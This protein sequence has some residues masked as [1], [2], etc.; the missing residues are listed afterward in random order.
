MRT[1]IDPSGR[2][3][4]PKRIRDRLGL[5]GNE[6]VEITERDGRIEIEPAPTDVEL[7]RDGSVLV[8]RP[9]RPLPPLT[10]DIVRETLE[11]VRRCGAGHQ[12]PGGGIRDWHEGTEH[13]LAG[14]ATYD[15]VVGLTARRRGN[16]VDP[17][18]ARS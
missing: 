13:D 3:V 14:G 7:V 5:R 9:G 4:I 17:R 6:E 15:A 1:T 2:L 16:L 10:D 8:A 11:R 18:P 12:R